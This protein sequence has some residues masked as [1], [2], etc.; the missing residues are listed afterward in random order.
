[1]EKL[2]K[3][4]LAQNRGPITVPGVVCVEVGGWEFAYNVG[5][6]AARKSHMEATMWSLTNQ[7]S[8][9][10]SGLYGG[11]LCRRNRVTAVSTEETDWM[12]L[13]EHVQGHLYYG[14]HVIDEEC[15]F[16]V[17]R[18]GELTK[19]MPDNPVCTFRHGQAILRDFV[20]QDA[21]DFFGDPVV[22]DEGEEEVFE[23]DVEEELWEG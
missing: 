21:V 14:P 17:I 18:P 12:G 15:R 3:Y 7:G 9:L 6:V 11:H 4:G 23:I 20:I 5:G 8:K 10:F 13:D 2:V 19:Y 22:V 16:K 1:M